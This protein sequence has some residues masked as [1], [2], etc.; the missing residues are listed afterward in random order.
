ML[1]TL[2][3]LYLARVQVEAT[4]PISVQTGQSELNYDTALVRDANGLPTLPATSIRGVLRHLSQ[5]Q[6]GKEQAQ[7]LFGYS[8]VD[9]T[10][11]SEEAQISHIQVSWGMLHNADNKPVEGLIREYDFL[12]DELKQS[13]PIKRERVRL[14]D[15]GCAED[16]GKFDV[17]AVPKGT[18]FT[19]ELKYWSEQKNDTNWQS[20]L[21]LMNQPAFRL[22][23][24]TRS[25]FGDLCVRHIMEGRY[26][27]RKAEDIASWQVLSRSL[28]DTHSL[29]KKEI[30]QPD[31]NTSIT[32]TINLTGEGFMR[33]GGGDLPVHDKKDP[34]DLRMQSEKYLTWGSG[35]AEFSQRYPL[36]PGSAIKGA[37]AH[38]LTFHD[39]RINGQFTD[40][41][42]S[43]ERQAAVDRKNTPIARQL[44][45]FASD[46]DKSQDGTRKSDGAAGQV[47]INDVYLDGPVQTSKLWHNKIDRFTGGVIDSALY[48]EEVLYQPE[49]TFSLTFLK[50]EEATPVARQAIKA[51]L[52]DLCQG[53]LSLGASGSR[54]LGSC[55]GNIDW[56]DDGQWIKGEA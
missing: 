45:G 30:K 1:K 9:K 39:N 12:L 11:H 22:G 25:G 49:F 41:M 4:T 20:L 31:N 21:N 37:L 42:D 56:S 27:L 13:Q 52:E 23:S 29:T 36:I 44:L 28:S 51:T 6:L 43:D 3:Y 7:S 47:L 55:T 54:G 48:S 50:P 19:F 35:K 46:T 18:R 8:Q 17:T 26:N 24:N 16:G 33:I 38:R 34:A 32:A 5:Q 14:N 10:T 40:K 53:R 2:H 15:K